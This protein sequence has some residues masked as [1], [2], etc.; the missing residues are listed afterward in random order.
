MEALNGLG[1]V[2]AHAAK[3]SG[4]RQLQRE[5]ELVLKF[6]KVVMSTI[7]QLKIQLPHHGDLQR[8]QALVSPAS[9]LLGAEK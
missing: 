3:I 9:Q 7:P 5:N 2:K 4:F 1:T 6:T 8:D